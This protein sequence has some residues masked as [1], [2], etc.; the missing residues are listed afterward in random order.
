MVV[1]NADFVEAAHYDR[2]KGLAP[3]KHILYLEL[4]VFPEIEP[5]HGNAF[6]ARAVLEHS[7]NKARR[8]G[9]QI[10]GALQL[11]ETC[12]VCEHIPHRFS[13]GNI[14]SRNVRGNEVPA[15]LKHSACVCAGFD[16]VNKNRSGN[17]FADGVPGPD[18]ES[19]GG[20]VGQSAAC[21]S[22]RR[23]HVKN[24]LIGYSP[25]KVL[26]EAGPREGLLRQPGASERRTKSVLRSIFPCAA[27]RHSSGLH[28]VGVVAVLDKVYYSGDIVLHVSRRRL[29]LLERICSAGHNEGIS[30]VG[31]RSAG[32][33]SGVGV[34]GEREHGPRKRLSG[35]LVLLGDDET[36]LEK[37][38]LGD[39]H[40]V[41]LRRVIG[42]DKIFREIFGG[43]SLVK[44]RFADTVNYGLVG[45]VLL[46]QIAER[47]APV[48]LGVQHQ[49]GHGV[50]V[51]IHRRRVVCQQRHGNKARPPACAVLA[52][53]PGYFNVYI[54]VSHFGK[55]RTRYDHARYDHY[56]AQK[57]TCKSHSADG[58]KY[59]VVLFK[60]LCFSHSSSESSVRQSCCQSIVLPRSRQC[61]LHPKPASAA[62]AASPEARLRRACRFIR[63]S[64]SIP[65]ERPRPAPAEAYSRP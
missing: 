14:K 20:V 8:G 7:L 33:N 37:V 39:V 55:R 3:V 4:P 49:V 6:E 28:A 61:L 13:R 1:G 51:N 25:A 21:I 29:D 42:P 60:R 45:G 17:G 30:A 43:V 52:V 54:K 12:T 16:P 27:E 19:V 65:P 48:I 56:Q 32:V 50:A 2:F 26:S 31:T 24:S 47:T 57:H 15:V 38:F 62:P 34:A 5:G 35:L 22:F 10:V 63:S 11:F 36:A 40:D 58:V 64:R 9:F 18:V 41:E 44:T 59:R 46:G 23:S 53:H